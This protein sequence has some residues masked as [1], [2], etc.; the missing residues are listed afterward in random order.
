MKHI[1]QI[2]NESSPGVEEPWY[3]VYLTEKSRIPIA[4]L[5]TRDELNTY[6]KYCGAFQYHPYS[7]KVKPS[8][9]FIVHNDTDGFPASPD[10]F[11]SRKS[12]EAWIER[13]RAS[14]KRNANEEFP[15]GVYKTSSCEYI[16]PK[17]INLRIEELEE[18]L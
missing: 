13:F 14:F 6:T 15:D 18:D 10:I 12:A 7:V 8:G 16:H 5:S 4:H 11:K 17:D 3:E 2:S 1:Y 9:E